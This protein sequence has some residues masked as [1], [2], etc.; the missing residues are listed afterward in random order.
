MA[1]SKGTLKEAARLGE[2]RT[3]RRGTRASPKN[4]G[5][6]STGGQRGKGL[7]NR[8]G[9]GSS[10]W[11]FPAQFPAQGGET[12]TFPFGYCWEDARSLGAGLPALLRQRGD[13]WGLCAL[14]STKKK[15]LE[16]RPGEQGAA[17]SLDGLSVPAAPRIKAEKET[18]WGGSAGWRSPQ[19]QSS[20]RVSVPCDIQ[21]D[22]KPP[23]EH[24]CPL[25][26][27]GYIKLPLSRGNSLAVAAPSPALLLP[28]PSPPLQDGLRART[29]LPRGEERLPLPVSFHFLCRRSRKQGRAPQKRSGVAANCP[30]G[31]APRQRGSS[32]PSP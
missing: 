20:P 27:V 22:F 9:D 12:A 6:E 5:A 15:D 26:H 2:E 25:Y 13:F 7:R 18:A 28:F 11:K 4:L 29:L 30:D 3:S 14:F 16:S 17:S 24:F 19:N 31:A 23:R 1:S 8:T 10:C 21:V 32:E